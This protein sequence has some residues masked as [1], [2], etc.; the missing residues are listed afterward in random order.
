[1]Q[2]KAVLGEIRGRLE[3]T[4]GARLK[5]VILYGSEARGD[6]RPDSDVGVLV[7]LADPVE[8][9]RDLQAN[10]DALYDLGVML[11]RRISA[12]PVSARDYEREDCPLSRQVRRE[13][14]AA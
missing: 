7:L 9:G 14:I 12:K 6:A 3:Q 11:G 2:T 5:G 4:H 1:M 10:I 13:G 8:Y